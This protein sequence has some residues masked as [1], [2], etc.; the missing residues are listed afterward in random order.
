LL[1]LARYIF[2]GLDFRYGWTGGFPAGVQ[3]AALAVS[4]LGYAIIPWAMANNRFF[5]QIV[6]IQSDRG[7][8]VSTGGPYRLVRHPSYVGMIL[9]ELAMP[10]M[11]ASWGSLLISLGNVILLVVRTA[12]EDRTLSVE[13]PGYAEYAVKTRYRLLPGVW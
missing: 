6:R 8:S 5:S 3:I 2:A 4:L 7:H 12:L 1:Q 11:L 10:V 13:L 9:F